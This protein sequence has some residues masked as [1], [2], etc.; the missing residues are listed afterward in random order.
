MQRQDAAGKDWVLKLLSLGFAI[1][2]WFF[3]VGEEKAEVSLSIP[4]EI[5]NLPAGLVIANDIPPSVDV[6]VYGPRSM[7][8][9]V[10]SQGLS[11]VVDL[12]G[13]SA[14]HLTVQMTP[15]S[16]PFPRG[17]RIMRVQPSHVD[18]ILET[19]TKKAIP[20]HA[21]LEGKADRDYMVKNVVAN[22]ANVTLAGPASEISRLHK[23]KTLPINLNGTAKTFTKLVGLDLQ[24]LHVTVE[25]KGL[26]EI[27]VHIAPVIT[28]KK[29]THIPV[30]V[31]ATKP[32]IS[33]WPQVVSM[34]LQG[35]TKLLRNIQPKDI[36]V[37]VST[38]DLPPGL[39]RVTPEYQVPKGLTPLET[40]PKKIRVRIPK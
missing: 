28:I 7:I 15:E 36:K 29:I 30:Q 1:T 39:H 18:I 16:L 31:E 21:V 22:P 9:A 14:G 4:L 3:V 19:L 20:V 23:I 34:R 6:R 5:V 10:T 27:T 17:L 38:K 12:R 40:I 8:K 32:G 25:G 24:G 2:L 26:V 35:W 33:W 13:T 37:V 11:R